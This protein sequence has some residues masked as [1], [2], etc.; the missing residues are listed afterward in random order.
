[1]GEYGECNK[2]SLKKVM[3]ERTTDIM[4]TRTL[5]INPTK[6]IITLQTMKIYE[7]QSTKYLKINITLTKS[8]N[9]RHHLKL[10]STKD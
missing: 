5:F 10:M 4:E 7:R 6:H 9:N 2:T 3:T 8:T 1:M